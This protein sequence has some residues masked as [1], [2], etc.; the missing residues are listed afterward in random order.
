MTPPVRKQSSDPGQHISEVCSSSSEEVKELI[1]EAEVKELI[2]D[3]K[4][5]RDQILRL[6]IPEKNQP[7]I[8]QNFI[9]AFELL[10]K[11]KGKLERLNKED[12]PSS[13]EL[14][15]VFLLFRQKLP[16]QKEAN[17][18]EQTRRVLFLEEQLAHIHKKKKAALEEALKQ[19]EEMQQKIRLEQ[20]K[21]FFIVRRVKKFLNIFLRKKK[22]AENSFKEMKGN[23]AY[24]ET[25][26]D[27]VCALS[28]GENEKKPSLKVK[29]KGNK[30]I[31][32]VSSLF[33]FGGLFSGGGP[34]SSY[35]QPPVDA[36]RLRF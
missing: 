2:T 20:K 21:G 8:V 27:I 17:L 5:M 30:M 35:K 3:A 12:L 13:K 33:S 14:H 36:P 23:T 32:R 16:W 31:G 28:G 4:E 6:N 19:Q 18:K 1:T 11:E 24:R 29:A 34:E 9:K 7:K 25:D 10:S 15:E 22:T 26:S